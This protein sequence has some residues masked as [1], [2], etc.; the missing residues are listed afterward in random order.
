MK[1]LLLSRVVTA[2]ELLRSKNWPVMPPLGRP[3]VV[4]GRV[5]SW[6][7]RLSVPPLLRVMLLVALPR[8]LVPLTVAV[9]LLTGSPVPTVPA[10]T[11]VSAPPPPTVIVLAP[12][13]ALGAAAEV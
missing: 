7:T 8:E 12:V 3:L 9:G 5:T 6:P 10:T 13:M 2:E 11:A 4:P 1:P